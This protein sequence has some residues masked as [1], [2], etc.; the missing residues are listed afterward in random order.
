VSFADTE[1]GHYGGVYRASNWIHIS[2][3]STSYYYIRNDEIMNKKTL[4]NNAVKS[5]LTEKQ[6]AESNNWSKVKTGIKHKFVHWL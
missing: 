3:S 2:D 1:Q 6:Y 5:G 4:Y